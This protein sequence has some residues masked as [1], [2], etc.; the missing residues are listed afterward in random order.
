MTE[1]AVFYRR[2]HNTHTHTHTARVRTQAPLHARALSCRK[3]APAGR[4]G[5][6]FHS[7]FHCRRRHTLHVGD[8][9]A[10]GRGHVTRV[11]AGSLRGISGSCCCGRPHAQAEVAWRLNGIIAWG[12]GWQRSCVRRMACRDKR[13][14]KHFSYWVRVRTGSWGCWGCRCGGCRCD[15]RR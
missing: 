10:R 15:S 11:I 12:C 3:D 13:R 14:G 2:T 4:P 9:P 7:F 1:A 5:G 6:F 8:W